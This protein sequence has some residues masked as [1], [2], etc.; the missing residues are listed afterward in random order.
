MAYSVGSWGPLR[1]PVVG[2]STVGETTTTDGLV[3]PVCERPLWGT[4]SAEATADPPSATL[5]NSALA[6]I[7]AAE[8]PL[9]AAITP[10]SRPAR[11]ER[12]TKTAMATRATVA[13]ETVS[14]SGRVIPSVAADA[15]ASAAFMCWLFL[16]GK[17]R[18]MSGT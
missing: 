1:S 7:P 15:A 6:R 18:F 16:S 11:R 5:T 3:L 8:T 17:E 4:A 2:G 9:A 13:R 12:L 10:V 14:T